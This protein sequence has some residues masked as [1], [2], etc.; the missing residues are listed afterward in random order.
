MA[1]ERWEHVKRVVAALGRAH[2]RAGVVGPPAQQRHV[3]SDLTN[4]ELAT[5]QELGNPS[6]NLPP[7]SFVG[8][9]VKDPGFRAEFAAVEA[10]LVRAV[11]A[12]KITRDR[13]LDL[14]GAFAAGKIR[15]TIIDDQVAPPL[16]S[17]TSAA[18]G[19]SKVLVDSGQLVAAIG[20]EVVK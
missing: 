9:T 4:G 17:S 18:K 12:G 2:V 8:K 13:A 14:L 19:H 6:T 11:I 3:G 20:W 5:L 10:R 16:A 7:R 15:Q 1:L